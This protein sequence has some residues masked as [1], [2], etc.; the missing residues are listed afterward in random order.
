MISLEAWVFSFW[1]V[2]GPGE[3]NDRPWSV[4]LLLRPP[5]LRNL[6]LLFLSYPLTTLR[7][8]RV[9]FLPRFGS[10][11]FQ[12]RHRVSDDPYVLDNPQS[13]GPKTRTETETKRYTGTHSV[14]EETRTKE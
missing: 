1:T 2:P 7:L 5:V 9:S 13:F 14:T 10:N 11:V 4:P 12:F 8:T 6:P 3:V